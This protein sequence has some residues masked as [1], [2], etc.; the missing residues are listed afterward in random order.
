MIER[1]ALS[2]NN[3]PDTFRKNW[4]N[5][6][7]DLGSTIGWIPSLWPVRVRAPVDA[8]IIAMLELLAL[9][10]LSDPNDVLIFH[11]ISITESDWNYKHKKV[12][13]VLD[14]AGY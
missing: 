2:N 12:E 11:T 13:R 1:D 7:D 9:L 3:W 5:I 6:N 8:S 10:Q 14:G 4:R